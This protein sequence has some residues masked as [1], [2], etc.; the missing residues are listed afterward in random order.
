MIDSMTP[1]ARTAAASG[2]EAGRVT[3]INCFAVPEGR[4]E[5]FERMWTEASA[6]FR[7]QPGFVSLRLHR[8]VTPGAQY[9]WI[10]VAVWESEQHY[11]AAH[12]TDEFRRVVTAD[13]WDEFP[14]VPNLYEVAAAVG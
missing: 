1:E 5:V 8:A 6:Y 11:L 12:G 3:L 10:N 9:R 2:L 13:G 7:A 14:N 4:D